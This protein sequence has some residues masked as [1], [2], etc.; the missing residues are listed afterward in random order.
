M[1]E[2]DLKREIIIKEKRFKEKSYDEMRRE[3]KRE[4]R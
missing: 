1:I 3:E 2:R 4:R